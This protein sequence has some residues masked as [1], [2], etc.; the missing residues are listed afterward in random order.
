MF[1]QALATL[2]GWWDL[3]TKAE[4][5]RHVIEDVKTAW[6]FWYFPNQVFPRECMVRLSETDFASV[7]A[8][9]VK[10]FNMVF[11][12]GLTSTPAEY[13]A[14]EVRLRMK[15][16]IAKKVS[17]THC[18]HALATSNILRE[19]DRNPICVT[20][21]AK[22]HAPT[23]LPPSTFE[24]KVHDNSL[25]EK[26]KTLTAKST[27]LNISTQHRELCF[28]SWLGFVTLNGD[29]NL[30]FRSWQSL[31]VQSG[32]FLYSSADGPIGGRRSSR[33]GELFRAVLW[34]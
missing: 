19:H 3:L 15:A 4:F 31:L 34:I 29:Y 6:D 24:S 21:A 26:A 27:W 5:D 8:F 9:L 2:K 1:T 10:R 20:T 33:G 18:W 7:S 28:A 23:S 32:Q 14:R 17:S 30:Y 13:A 25:G 11:T 16:N 12:A 22:E